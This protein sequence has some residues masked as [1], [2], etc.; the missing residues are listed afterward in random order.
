MISPFIQNLGKAKGFSQ[1]EQLV[2]QIALGPLLDNRGGGTMGSMGM[3]STSMG[4]TSMGSTGM[5][6]PG[7]KSNPWFS[8]IA[9]L[10]TLLVAH[11]TLQK[12]NIARGLATNPSSPNNSGSVSQQTL[13]LASNMASVGNRGQS[14]VP[15]KIAPAIPLG[16][17]QNASNCL[18]NPSHK[19]L[20]SGLHSLSDFDKL[21]TIKNQNKLVPLAPS[22][23][24]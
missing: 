20:N 2:L 6:F 12:M 23:N 1:D 19:T 4:S 13:Q 10:A 9:T 3:G 18:I 21:V 5:G 15:M 17:L 22:P 8:M 16:Q 11:Q 14:S 24:L 7:A